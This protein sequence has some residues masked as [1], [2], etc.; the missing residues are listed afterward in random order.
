M[1]S[2]RIFA[3]ILALSLLERI[4]SV[5]VEGKTRCSSGFNR[6]DSIPVIPAASMTAAAPVHRQMEPAMEIASVTPACAPFMIAAARALPFPLKIE[7]NILIPA[8][9]VQIQ[10]MTIDI[11]PNA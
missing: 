6:F 1:P 5:L 2:P 9:P 8:M 4:V 7:N 10:L 11:P 3:Q